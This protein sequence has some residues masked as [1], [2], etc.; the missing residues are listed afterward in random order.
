MQPVKSEVYWD[1]GP[2]PDSLLVVLQCW[3]FAYRHICYYCLQALL[4]YMFFLKKFHIF[5]LLKLQSKLLMQK[6]AKP[7]RMFKSRFE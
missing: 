3:C 7:D 1:E 4:F 6:I 2:Y 5:K